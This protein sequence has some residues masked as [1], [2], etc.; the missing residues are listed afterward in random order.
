[1]ENVSKFN[2]VDASGA[3]T[4]H[5][6]AELRHLQYLRDRETDRKIL[7][8]LYLSPRWKW[9]TVLLR[10]SLFRSRLQPCRKLQDSGT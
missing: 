2:S 4:R 9:L 5:W 1:M 8:V 3:D 10:R 6:T 7:S